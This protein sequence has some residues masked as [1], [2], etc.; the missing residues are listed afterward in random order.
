M[1]LKRIMFYLVMAAASGAS[2]YAG[3]R[4]IEADIIVNADVKS[5]WQA[6]TTSDGVQ[7]F[8][9]PACNLDLRV[10]GP[11]EM[12]FVPEADSGNRG[13]EG[14]RILAIQPEKMLA[15]TWNAPP[16]LPTVRPQRTHVVIR[17][18]PL[19]THQTRLTVVHDGWG[20][21][22]EWEKAYEYFQRAWKKVVLPRLQYRFSNGPIDWE[23]P[24]KM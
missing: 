2:T 9:A 4:A 8:F 21:G 14:N 10:D 1:K 24:P 12:F 3:D 16:N 7:A 17:F 13:G 6:W 18:Y 5:V 11:Y 20:E 23:N 19:S 15:F 22:G